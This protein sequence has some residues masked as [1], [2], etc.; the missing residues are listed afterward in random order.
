M[1]RYKWHKH[2][3]KNLWSNRLKDNEEM[4]TN[5]LRMM[6]L[7]NEHNNTTQRHEGAA[8]DVWQAGQASIAPPVD[9]MPLIEG[10]VTDGIQPAYSDVYR[11]RDDARDYL[12]SIANRVND[13]GSN[14]HDPG[15]RFRSSDEAT[16]YRRDRERARRTSRHSNLYGAS[17]LDS[18]RERGVP[19]IISEEAEARRQLAQF[20][21]GNWN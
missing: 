2:K 20:H 4:Q 12:Q 5:V 18:I 3:K 7:F 14:P 11:R 15:P 10:R 8:G 19:L 1:G 6:E 9:Y 16:Q 13:R 21:E 17:V